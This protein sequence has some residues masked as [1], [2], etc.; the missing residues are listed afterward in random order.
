MP[1]GVEVWSNAYGEVVTAP[2]PVKLIAKG[3]PGP[4]LLVQVL[5]SK[6]RDKCPLT[7]QVDIF[8]RLGV[9]LSRNTLVDWVGAA[10]ELLRPLSRAIYALVLAAYV[11]QVDD[12]KLPVLDRRKAKNIKHGHLWTLVGDHRYVAYR[13]TENW[14][15]SARCTASRPRPRKPASGPTNG[16]CAASARPGHCSMPGKSGSTSTRV[17]SHPRARWARRSPM[18]TIIG[19]P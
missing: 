13:Y 5:L 2:V 12:T 4:A 14:C 7:R 16:C 9:E 15:S 19:T 3:L 17:A 18:R 6:F 10:A 11:L 1:E 8:R